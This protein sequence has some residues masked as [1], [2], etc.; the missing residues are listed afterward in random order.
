MSTAP[1]DAL[2]KAT[3]SQVERAADELRHVLPPELLARVD[4]ASLSLESGSF[5]DEALRER[6]TDLLFSLRLD[7]RDARIYL[8]FEHQSGPDS[9]MPL[10]L[11]R[12]MLRIWEGC[13]AAGATLLPVVIPV[14]LHHGDAGWRAP[15]RFEALFDLPPEAAEFT[16]HFRFLLD[17]LATESEAALRARAASAFTRLVLSALQQSRGERHLGDLLR[18]WT[19]L[20]RELRQAPDGRRALGLIYRYLYE[21]RGRAELATI[22]AVARENEPENEDFMET[23]ADYLRAQGAARG[24]EEGLREGQRRFLL[25]MMKN[26][27]GEL[28]EHVRERVMAGDDAELTRW[29]ARLLEARSLDDIFAGP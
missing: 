16:P 14:V 27:F 1:H 24:R 6:H 20:I 19:G 26:R 23:I 3:F 17:D 4:L 8:L 25:G 28:P 11:L 29:G 7:G 21:V 18:G 22:T 15:T 12:Y 10:R 2:F 13:V 9:W 5:V